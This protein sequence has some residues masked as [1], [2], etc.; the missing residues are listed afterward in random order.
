LIRPLNVLTVRAE[1]VEAQSAIRQGERILKLHEAGSM[2]SLCRMNKLLS[3]SFGE[4]C[5]GDIES[6][7]HEGNDQT[8]RTGQ[9]MT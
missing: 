7:A 2:F 5:V 9:K 6:D 4:A 3:L 1:L 8:K